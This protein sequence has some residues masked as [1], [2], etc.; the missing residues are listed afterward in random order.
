MSGSGKGS[1]YL[2]LLFVGGIVLVLGHIVL[3][4]R[5][6]IAYDIPTTIIGLV[7][8]AIALRG[9]LGQAI[10][11]RLHGEAS[12]DALPPEH[13]IAELDELRT[14]VAE[15]EERADFSER[16]LAQH[17]DPAGSSRSEGN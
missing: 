10:A 3:A 14:R 7:G 4:V 5:L 16:L 8:A 2:P 15:L 9:P 6:G 1:D 13:V 17:R 11:R 12:S